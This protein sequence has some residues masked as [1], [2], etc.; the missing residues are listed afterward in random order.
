[1]PFLFVPITTVSY[2]AVPPN[3]SNNASALVN[4]MRNLGGSFG[5]SL[6][7]SL[8]ARRSQYHHSRLAE[9]VNSFSPFYQAQAQQQSLPAFDKIVQAQASMLSYIDVFWLLAVLAAAVIPLTFLL[10]RVKP[11]KDAAH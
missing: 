5:I 1:L 9:S 8:V 7:V 6:A 11:G 2:A 4:T 10:Q 3:K